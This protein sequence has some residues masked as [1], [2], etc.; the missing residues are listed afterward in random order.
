MTYVV[1][2]KLNGH[3]FAD[4]IDGM[5]DAG[6]KINDILTRSPEVDYKD[7]FETMFTEMTEGAAPNYS[8]DVADGGNEHPLSDAPGKNMFEYDGGKSFKLKPQEDKEVGQDMA[9]NFVIPGERT[10]LLQSSSYI[11][12]IVGGINTIANNK[13]TPLEVKQ[14]SEFLLAKIFLA[15][16]H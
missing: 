11:A 15:R 7:I 3:F 2:K 6:V 14:I 4:H 12:G 10:N 13:L 5:V 16:C 9:M 1:V 8:V